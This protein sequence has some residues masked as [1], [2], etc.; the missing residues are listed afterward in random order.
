MNYKNRQ[1]YHFDISYLKTFNG[2]VPVYNPSVYRE[3]RGEIFTTYHTTEHPVTNIVPSNYNVH[4]RFSK[5]YQNVLRGLH[6]DD[7]PA[8]VVHAAKGLVI[9]TL[10]VLMAGFPYEPCRAL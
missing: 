10:G 4:S 9:D 1:W 7:L 2:D 5:S 3:Y 6:Y 8:G